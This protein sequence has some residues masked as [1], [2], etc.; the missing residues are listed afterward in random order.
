L[1]ETLG[2]RDNTQDGGVDDEVRR[3]E[4]AWY[5]LGVSPD[6]EAALGERFRRALAA[7][8]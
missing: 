7:L 3:I 5:L 6:Q 1:S 4:A 2:R 8:H